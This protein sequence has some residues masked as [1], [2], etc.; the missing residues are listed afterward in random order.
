MSDSKV[1]YRELDPDKDL[2]GLRAC[3]V[4]LQDFEVQLYTRLPP[5]SEVADKCVA[6]MLEQCEKCT[7]KIIVADVDGQLAG[8]VTVLTQVRSDEP[9]DGDMVYGLISDLAVL[10]SF[11][12]L[13]IGTKLLAV[14]EEFAR[15]E[16][17]EWLRIG[18]LAGNQVAEKLYASLGFSPW[19]IE[20]EKNLRATPNPR[21]QPNRQ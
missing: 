10:T 15:S 6:H 3:V 21:A 17:V 8:F 20:S 1:T 7:G 18:V 13:G 4:E 14:A 5:G 11:R 2:D 12:S 19:H 16:G 9:D